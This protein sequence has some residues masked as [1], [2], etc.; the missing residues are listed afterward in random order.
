MIEK[1]ARN[2]LSVSDALDCLS[3]GRRTLWSN[4][5]S[6]QKAKNPI[7]VPTTAAITYCIATLQQPMRISAI[8]N[9]ATNCNVEEAY[10]RLKKLLGSVGYGLEW[11][12]LVGLVYHF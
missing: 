11:Q 5:A 10:C 3:A 6:K 1:T 2:R 9:S 12:S 8:A 7:P 4:G